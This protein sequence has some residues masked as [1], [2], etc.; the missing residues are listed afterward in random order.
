MKLST[1]LL[2]ASLVVTGVCWPQPATAQDG[3][4]APTEEARKKASEHFQ[5]GVQ[6]YRE[7]DFRNALI[8]FKRAHEVAPSYQVLFNLG[9]TSFELK[10][11]VEAKKSFEAYLEQGGDK[12]DAERKQ[13]V[14]A[15]LAKLENYVAHIALTANVDGAEIAIDDIEVGTTPL[16]EPLL[17]S[18][19]RRKVELR[20][21]GYAPLVRY[22]DVGGGETKPVVLELVSLEVKPAPLPGPAP[23]ST[24]TRERSH[25]GFWIGFGTTAAFGVATIVMGSLALKANGD[26]EDELAK[27]PNNKQAL[28]DAAEKV[29]SFALV[30]DILA[31][32][33]GAAAI[34]TLVVG[35]VSF[36]GD[37][38][39]GEGVG[40]V[41]SPTGAALS[42]RF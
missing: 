17:V 4:A 42:G 26:H 5:R 15:E 39:S 36:S 27:F 10:D 18:A 24:P 21:A 13:E 19:G 14:Q 28:D 7:R 11:Y 6:F 35:I 33:T 31:G 25:A 1:C 34:A 9:Q 2:L 32:F 38:E 16:S 30:T 29:T 23:P 41:V 8:E 12:I 3:P 40:L 22:V 37:D 20:K